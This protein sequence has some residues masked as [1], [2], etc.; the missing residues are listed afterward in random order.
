MGLN[1]DYQ[2]KKTLDVGQIMIDNSVEFLKLSLENM[3]VVISTQA[4]LENWAGEFYR[5]FKAETAKAY[6]GWVMRK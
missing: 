6:R 5:A 2:K 3:S 1:Y 4:P